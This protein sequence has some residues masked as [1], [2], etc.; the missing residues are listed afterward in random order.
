MRLI[1][2]LNFD[3]KCGEAFD[4]YA[5]VLDGTIDDLRRIAH[6]RRDAGRQP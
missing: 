5:A 4:F 3:G 6:L 2:Y 1:P